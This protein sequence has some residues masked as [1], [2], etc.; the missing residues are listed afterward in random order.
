MVFL[1]V[2]VRFLSLLLTFMMC[3]ELT[4]FRFSQAEFRSLS[5]KRQSVPV[6]FFKESGS[7]LQRR[8][9]STFTS[10]S[11]RPR[12][13]SVVKQFGLA[14]L[15]R[16]SMDPVMSMHRHA[17]ISMQSQDKRLRRGSIRRLSQNLTKAVNLD[18]I[19]AKYR[20][21]R[22][23]NEA[24]DLGLWKFKKHEIDLNFAVVMEAWS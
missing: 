6:N 11:L 2:C 15:A 9:S 7:S 3:S 13:H 17:S 20:K 5:Q 14:A 1:L 19:Q 10:L 16:Q 8:L 24:V 21:K 23:E 12:K 4:I 18:G 22:R